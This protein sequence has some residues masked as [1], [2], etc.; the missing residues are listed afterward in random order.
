MVPEVCKAIVEAYKDEVFVLP[1]T[2]DE[3]RALARLTTERLQD[4]LRPVTFCFV[5][6]VTRAY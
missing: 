2:P 3:W 6:F 4:L 5:L 1:V